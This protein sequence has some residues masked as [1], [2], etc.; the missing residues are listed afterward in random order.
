M[1]DMGVRRKLLTIEQLVEIF[2]ASCDEFKELDFDG[3]DSAVIAITLK[4]AEETGL[5]EDVVAERL[6]PF[7][8]K[9]TV[10]RLLLSAG[11]A[12][13]K[14]EC[15]KCGFH[16]DNAAFPD[17]FK[18]CEGQHM[19]LEERKVR[20]NK[21]VNEDLADSYSHFF[22]EQELKQ[23]EEREEVEAEQQETQLRVK[24]AVQR[25]RHSERLWCEAEAIMARDEDAQRMRAE[26]V[27]ESEALREEAL[28]EID[29]LGLDPSQFEVRGVWSL[30]APD[31]GRQRVFA[32]EGRRGRVAS[33]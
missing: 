16:V 25:L 31:G 1:D 5:P 22:A 11:V 21:F 20:K 23:K 26:L 7:Q 19:T 29:S 30:V 6:L 14:R 8:D 33:I 28:D 9:V 18:K 24:D 2:H 3:F 17:H 27:R 13:L 4:L 15:P 12:S 32:V 10:H